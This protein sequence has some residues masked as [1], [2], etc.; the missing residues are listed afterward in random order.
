MR[1]KL[2]HGDAAHN[3]NGTPALQNATP[4]SPRPNCRLLMRGCRPHYSHTG[5]AR[6]WCYERWCSKYVALVC[7]SGDAAFKEAHSHANMKP[8][9][10]HMA[11]YSFKHIY[12]LLLILLILLIVSLSSIVMPYCAPYQLGL[13][14]GGGGGRAL[15]LVFCCRLV[16]T[17]TTLV[18][19]TLVPSH[20]YH[21]QSSHH[22]LTH[23]S[24]HKAQD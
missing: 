8:L 16:H 21:I 12:W 1:Y 3:E 10:L 24:T 20:W 19:Y 15:G 4:R 11:P 23:H 17:G 14:L 2:R 18:P 9:R 5:V 7:G 13:G 6:R 22:S